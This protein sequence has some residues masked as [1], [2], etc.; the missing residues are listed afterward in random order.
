MYF[1]ESGFWDT[2][3]TWYTNT[4]QLTSCFQATVL[5]YTPALTLVVFGLWDLNTCYH[6]KSRTVPWSR[7]L[8]SKLILTSL[9]LALALLELVSAIY[10]YTTVDTM[11]LADILAPL[12]NILS[13]LISLI[14][15]VTNKHFGQ[16]ISVALFLFWTANSLCL[17]LSLVSE[18]FGSYE[19]LPITDLVLLISS[20]LISFIMFLL[21][22]F[23]D[24]HPLYTEWDEQ[25]DENDCPRKF[26]SVPSRILLSWMDS[27][28]I[29][30]YRK[31]L[32][33]ADLWNLNPEDR[34]TTTV[35]AL[36]K[37]LDKDNISILATLFKCHWKT[38]ILLTLL[39]ISKTLLSL[40]NPQIID[41]VISFVEEDQETWKGYLYMILFGGVTLG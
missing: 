4:P 22:C 23:A 13:Y 40:V 7:P 2:N 27:L 34:L 24:M 1:C 37:K 14:L 9:S 8:L 3:L 26:A 30:G 21:N 41:M 33:Q 20:L 35:P 39:Y 38:F 32:T 36:E 28:L 15:L 10:T 25:T 19:D 31:P 29:K 16:V 17:G 11:F 6:S 12:V 18:A 5:V